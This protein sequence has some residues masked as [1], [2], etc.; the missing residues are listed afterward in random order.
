MAKILLLMAGG[1]LG[2]LA[3][4]LLAGATA[5]TFGARFP[6]GTLVVNL[7]GCF[8]AGFLVILIENKFSSFAHAKVLILVGFLGAFTTF[9]TFILETAHLIRSGQHAV[10]FANVMISV[11]I[12]FLLFELGILVGKNL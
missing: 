3:R 4:Y 6:Y 12:G 2:T 8:L 9:S 10:A 11:A 7:L 5:Q 1:G